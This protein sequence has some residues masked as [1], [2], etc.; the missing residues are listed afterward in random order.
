MRSGSADRSS[1]LAVSTSAINRSSSSTSSPMV[2]SR[3]RTPASGASISSIATLIRAS[4]VRSSCETFA[5]S[6]FS[7]R[8]RAAWIRSAISSKLRARRR[9]ARPRRGGRRGRRHL[10]RRRTPPPRA[11]SFSSGRV[12]ERAR[13]RRPGRRRRGPAGPRAPTRRAADRA[14]R[15]AAQG[16]VDAPQHRA[17][18]RRSDDPGAARPAAAHLLQHADLGARCAGPPRRAPRRGADQRDVHPQLFMDLL[19]RALQGQRLRRRR[20]HAREVR[21]EARASPVEGEERTAGEERDARHH[22]HHRQQ[23]AEEREVEAQVEAPRMHSGLPRQQIPRPADRLHVPRVAR[24]RLVF[25]RRRE[26]WTSM[27][28]SKASSA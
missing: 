1:R 16:K 10:L 7:A 15:G 18:G 9:P 22:Q 23:H 25:W 12:I 14:P 28:R 27:L 11:V 26:T 20:E 8:R 5:R 4:G 19:G 17:A 6:S 13:Q 21:R 24:V 3:L 2:T